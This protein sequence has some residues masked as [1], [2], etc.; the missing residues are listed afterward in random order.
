MS[1]KRSHDTADVLVRLRLETA[2]ASRDVLEPAGEPSTAKLPPPE[3][4]L[5]AIYRSAVAEVAMSQ[6]DA[7]LEDHPGE[8]G[9]PLAAM[10]MVLAVWAPADI[11]AAGLCAA[12]AL[13]TPGGG[14]VRDRGISVGSTRFV[15]PVA[16]LGALLEALATAV[17][18]VMGRNDLSAEAKAAWSCY[19][20]LALHPFPDGNG[21][22]ARALA[23]VVLRCLGTPFAIG[24]AAPG[25][26]REA[27]RSALVSGHVALGDTRP[28]A[29]L[30][31]ERLLHGWEQVASV[32]SRRLAAAR[33]DSAAAALRSAR[34]ALKREASCVCCLGEAPDAA[35]LCCGGAAHI[36]CMADWLAT[37]AV[38]PCCRADVPL[39]VRVRDQ[40]AA[41]PSP[42]GNTI[43]SDDNSALDYMAERLDDSALSDTETEDSALDS[44]LDDAVVDD[45]A[46]DGAAPD[47]NTDAAV[48]DSA[49]DSTLDDAV[50]DDSALDGA[51]PHSNTDAAVDDSA[52]DSTLDDAVVDDSALDGTAPDNNTDA[53]VD[54]SALDST[55]DDA[56]V[57]DSALDGA[58][59]D[60]N[61]DAAVDD[62]ALDS[63]LDDAAS[64]DSALDGAGPQYSSAPYGTAGLDDSAIDDPALDAAGGA[65]SGGGSI[66]VGSAATLLDD[67]AL[68]PADSDPDDSA[69]D[70]ELRAH[71][72]LDDSAFDDS[73][74]PQL[75]SIPFHLFRNAIHA[76]PPSAP[77]KPRSILFQEA[78]GRVSGA[79]EKRFFV[80]A[81]YYTA[82]AN[83]AM[84]VQAGAPCVMSNVRWED[85]TLRMVWT[86][87][88]TVGARKEDAVGPVGSFGIP[89]YIMP[90]HKL[91]LCQL[92]HGGTLSVHWRNPAPVRAV[93]MHC[94]IAQT[95]QIGDLNGR[96]FL[97]KLDEPLSTP[98]AIDAAELETEFNFAATRLSELVFTSNNNGAPTP[99]MECAMEVATAGQAR[100]MLERFTAI[101]FG[102]ILYSQHIVARLRLSLSDS[103][104]SHAENVQRRVEAR[105]RYDKI[106]DVLEA[107]VASSPVARPLS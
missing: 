91:G 24:F 94:L 75:G 100:E 35:M 53:A 17:R 101:E 79:G 15:E 41:V 45:S 83:H 58:A 12:H 4:D 10:H 69:L 81:E 92:Q 93:V 102:N 8:G 89:I 67:S 97:A 34:E 52:L 14:Q 66:G 65:T 1:R 21:R 105:R 28:L 90:K 50:V 7:Q 70:S 44:T 63:T 59:P 62:S 13:F 29:L 104:I 23:N 76:Q 9:I 32:F 60:N 77:L 19:S 22:L 71:P 51:A 48:D 73:A 25:A 95:L 20:L 106:V 61:T 74:A 3:P 57:D 96:N 40:V 38:C 85:A 11:T 98:V 56:V 88:G 103:A 31:R 42:E 72:A 107:A 80:A 46:L 6:R 37:K 47:N 18:A 86:P 43:D 55:L 54:D 2:L 84:L 87:L 49:L 64:D 78:G 82:K 36:C 39:R 16:E 68:D 99:E 26:L 30:L 5:A 27:Y 33:S